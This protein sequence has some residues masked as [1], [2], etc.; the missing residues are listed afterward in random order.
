VSRQPPDP[1]P[2]DQQPLRPHEV[3]H[4]DQRE[5]LPPGTPGRRVD[6]ARPGAA[7]AAAERVGADDE[8]LVCIER[9][10][11]ADHRLPPTGLGV[12]G[13]V[14]SG[15]VRVAGERMDQQDGVIPRSIQRPIG[16]VDQIERGQRL[17]ERQPK[18]RGLG[19]GE[20]HR[21]WCH[22]SHARPCPYCHRWH[23]HSPRRLPL[24]PRRRHLHRP[25]PRLALLR[26]AVSLVADLYGRVTRNCQHAGVKIE[27]ISAYCAGLA[28][29]EQQK[30]SALAEVKG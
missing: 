16:L 30:T 20:M 15:S 26:C 24:S 3:L 14:S 19:E 7:S 22:D 1:E 21:L 8:I 29:P 12:G 25:C 5:R 10:T 17:T 11:G 13:I 27:R 4:R 23:L 18:R 6:A 28:V 9:A 2:V